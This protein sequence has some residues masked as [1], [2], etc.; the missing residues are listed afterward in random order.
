MCTLQWRILT[1][2][3]VAWLVFLYH[4]MSTG[5]WEDSGQGGILHMQKTHCWKALPNSL[6]INIP[7]S[8]SSPVL[9][10]RM[11]RFHLNMF[12]PWERG[13]LHSHPIK[14]EILS[15]GENWFTSQLCHRKMC[16]TKYWN[17]KLHEKIRQ[18]FLCHRIILLNKHTQGLC[19]FFNRRYS[20]WIE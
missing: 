20:R 15:S 6:D 9:L 8:D 16:H 1:S 13:I 3:I 19:I 18:N 4:L 10:P 2:L 12:V 11:N 17:N 14:T 7:M 5:R